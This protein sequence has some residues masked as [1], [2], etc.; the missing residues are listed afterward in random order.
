M[1]AP[2]R[3]RLVPPPPSR[4]EPERRPTDTVALRDLQ[5]ELHELHQDYVTFW[6]AVHDSAQ[7]PLAATLNRLNARLEDAAL[8]LEAAR[9][10]QVVQP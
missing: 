2:K 1:S 10:G 6:H 4:P 8:A 3:P 9:G 7:S 5:D